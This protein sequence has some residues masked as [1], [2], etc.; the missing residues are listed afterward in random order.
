MVAAMVVAM[1]GLMGSSLTLAL[2]Q[3]SAGNVVSPI[4][5]NNNNI[6]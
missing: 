3:K 6:S 1:V 5:C 2:T 4:R